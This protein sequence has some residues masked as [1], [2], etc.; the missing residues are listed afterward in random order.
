[1]LEV[2]LD[3]RSIADVLEMTVAEARAFFDGD[4]DI[5]AA[6]QP[7]VDVGLDYLRLGQPVPNV[8]R[9]R[10]A[11]AQ[12][13]GF[14]AS[15]ARSPSAAR[16]TLFLFDEPTTGLHFDDVARLLRALRK[17]IAAGHS[18]VVIEHNL[19]VIR[20]A[21]WIVDLGPEGGDAGGEVVVCGTVA[22]VIAC[23]ASHTGA[24]LKRTWELPVSERNPRV[25]GVLGSRR[26]G[27]GSNVEQAAPR[28]RCRKRYAFTTRGSTT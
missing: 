27:G 20:A 2:A 21:D 5:D 15:A 8:V 14:L 6:L 23:A 18:L 1:V 22:E 10:G 11:T 16:G 4:R 3:G 13:R 28:L 7:L 12:A 24:A 26:Y 17:L 25:G 9:R 19:D